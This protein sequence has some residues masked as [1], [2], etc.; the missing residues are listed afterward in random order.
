MVFARPALVALVL[1]LAACD[2]DDD[3]GTT[4]GDTEGSDTDTDGG[5]PPGALGG[6][7]LAPDG[8][9]TEGVCNRDENYCFDPDAPCEGFSC[10][11]AD[12]GSCTPVDGEPSCACNTG[13]ESETFRLYCCPEDGSDPVCV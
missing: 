5:S 11:G 7:C 3:S 1:C 13:F 4:A 9:C 8:T 10:G 2:A 6:L 12:R